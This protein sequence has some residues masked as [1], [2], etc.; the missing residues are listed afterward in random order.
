MT[1]KGNE[2]GSQPPSDGD[3]KTLS[4]LGAELRRDEAT[5]RILKVRGG[6]ALPQGDDLESTVRGFLQSHAAEL[7]LQADSTNLRLLQAVATP[8]R[9]ILRFEQTVSGIPVLG[10]TVLVQLDEKAQK[11]VQVDLNHEP[12]AKVRGE[13][14]DG[15]ISAEKALEIATSA[16]EE[17]SPRQEPPEPTMVYAPTDEGLRLA[18]QVLVPTREPAHDW[19]FLVDATTGEV[20]QK[21][22]LLFHVDGQGLVFDPN[23]VVTSNNNALRDPN[24][25]GTCGFAPSS[26]ATVD[27]EQVTR[28]LRDLTFSAGV[29]KLEGPF[30]KLRDFGP[31]NIAPPTEA[32][33]SDFTYPSDDDRF[34]AVMV[35]YHV[36]SLQRYIQ[37]LGV[38]TAHNSQIEADAHDGSGGAWFSPI[39]QGIHF[40]ASGP[41]RPD[42][43][44]EADAILHEYGHA[45]QY[46][47]VPGWGGTN[48]ITGR[49][50]TRAM[51]EGFGDILACLY[52][53]ERGGGFQREVF[54][55][56]VFGDV[57]GLRRVDGTKVYPT[58]WASEEHED[59]EIWSA[60]LWNIY[61]AIG[62]DSV[63]AAT[64]AVARDE[65]LK[66]LILSHHSVAGNATMP[67][68]A[69]ALLNTDAELEE[70]RGKHLIAMLDSFHDR[71]ILPAS[72]GADLY[73]RD[74]VGDPGADAF[75]GPVFWDS[76]DLW[77]RHNDDG[78]TTHQAPEFG[79]DNWF[80]ARV[81]NRGTQTARAFAV[82]FNVKPWAG[83]EFTYPVDFIPSISAAVGYDLAPGG[84]TVVKAR[85]P[86]ALVPAPG[87]HACWLAS[88]Y[89]PLDAS[90][91]GRHPWEHNNLAQKNLTI[92]DLEPG[93]STI[94]P[95]Q[96]GNRYRIEPELFRV[97]VR[98][99]ERWQKMPVSLVRGGS[100]HFEKLLRARVETS[101]AGGKRRRPKVHEEFLRWDG[102]LVEEPSRGFELAFRPNPLAGTPVLLEPRTPLQLGLKVSLPKNAKPGETVDIHVVQRNQSKKVIGG[103]TVRVRTKGA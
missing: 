24:A 13:V 32:S 62:G 58:D 53:A 19:Q 48:P 21:S 89:T 96:I 43:G 102:D 77:V 17:G 3:A 5:N 31:P 101:T 11:V 38:L 95:F 23:P 88:V 54:E 26:Q 73:I 33:A 35:Y 97:E 39:D 76:P 37:S 28:S 67:D 40:G 64:R 57:G 18:Y 60:A 47:Q 84:S 12:A 92:V 25:A 70:L 7:D 42:R 78:G 45:I 20:F 82:T 61:R 56:W 69:E 49:A 6:F 8:T 98:R 22:D 14:A 59:G 44:E 46:D 79:Q 87:T 10:S 68:A 85:W 72:A 63:S 66:A 52:F 94:V 34:E 51:G 93:D 80:Y 4:A 100:R 83:L 99:P 27:A 36:D 81:R 29:H 91:A 16:L 9:R 1:G 86:A 15:Q 2:T 71:G 65:L 50:E 74:A 75:V 41:C 55:D 90:P 30:V 103:I